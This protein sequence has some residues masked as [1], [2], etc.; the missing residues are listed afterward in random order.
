MSLHVHICVSVHD[1]YV[2]VGNSLVYFRFHL[3]I[4]FKYRNVF[5]N[6]KYIGIEKSYRYLI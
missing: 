4:F 1:A 6:E 3:Y 5:R 2:C